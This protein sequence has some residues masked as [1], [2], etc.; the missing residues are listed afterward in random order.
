[1][2]VEVT[3]DRI[4][5]AIARH[6]D[7]SSTVHKMEPIRF[8]EM[9]GVR[10]IDKDIVSK[11]ESMATEHNVCAFVV[12]WPLQPDGRMGA[13]CGKVLHLLDE[14]A[15]KSDKFFTKDRP[16]TLWDDRDIPRENI[17][18]SSMK[19]NV[20]PPDEWGRSVMFS[21]V[22]P[23]SDEPIYLSRE[24]G[25]HPT[26]EDSSMAA[27]IL[28]MFIEKNYDGAE[29]DIVGND[30]GADASCYSFEHIGEYDN[31]NA[32]VQVSMS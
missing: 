30:N 3:S 26:S 14:L 8:K 21:R 20:P 28:E 29:M 27:E 25:N 5:I 18:V 19:L 1:M 32:R 15:A 13:P 31:G 2:S 7:T 16:F 24:L 23:R 12:G 4:G 17:D 6:P 22:R 11:L 9:L 10:K